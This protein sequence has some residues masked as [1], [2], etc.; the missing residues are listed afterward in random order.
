M[1]ELNYF[2]NR[3]KIP[4]KEELAEAFASDGSK[5]THKGTFFSPEEEI[6]EKKLET[7]WGKN[8]EEVINAIFD[9]QE[10]VDGEE[11]KIIEK[12]KEIA[13]KFLKKVLEDIDDYI[14]QINNLKNLS[15]NSDSENI[16][17]YQAD[18]KM[19]DENRRDAH[20][21][22]INDLKITVRFLNTCFNAN[23]PDEERIKIEK[24]YQDRIGKSEEEIREINKDKHFINFSTPGVVMDF[25]N[26]P[27]DPIGERNYIAEWAFGIFD[28]LAVLEKE[29]PRLEKEKRASFH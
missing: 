12:R 5:R 3:E 21:K 14:M 19:S 1:F 16:K 9:Y 23:F 20:N 2:L 10:D 13:L 24:G 7:S 18:Y 17:D 29:I 28:D 27:K 8:Y 22:L 25:S 15:N 4:S 11:Q 6:K 26:M